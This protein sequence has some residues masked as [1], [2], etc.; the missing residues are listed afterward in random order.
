MLFISFFADMIHTVSSLIFQ[1]EV[2]RRRRF[3]QPMLSFHVQ[4]NTVH[5]IRPFVQ[6]LSP[7]FLVY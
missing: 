6:R 3:Q 1:G 4:K 5:E 2:D 7:A